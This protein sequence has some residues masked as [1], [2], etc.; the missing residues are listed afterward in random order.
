M[1]N[2]LYKDITA[3]TSFYKISLFKNSTIHVSSINSKRKPQTIHTINKFNPKLSEIEIPLNRKPRAIYLDELYTFE[4][5]LPKIKTSATELRGKDLIKKIEAEYYNELKI[6]NAQKDSLSNTKDKPSLGDMIEV[7][8]YYSLTSGTLN[9]ISGVVV[10]VDNL[11]NYKFKFTILF[12]EEGVYGK[13][14]FHYYSDIVKAIKIT[15][16]NE[17]RELSNKIIGYKQLQNFGHISKLLIKNLRYKKITKKDTQKVK[18]Y[19]R[20][21]VENEF[22][23]DNEEF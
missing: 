12:H 17:S 14:G 3:F 18:E 20:N 1:K 7:D 10:G 22:I 6:K 9:R 13:M 16:K 4:K 8:Y 2:L 23:E 19:L 15:S 5:N 11:D 21:E